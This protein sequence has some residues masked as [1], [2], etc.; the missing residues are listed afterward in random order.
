MLQPVGRVLYY[1]QKPAHKVGRRFIGGLAMVARFR[2][3]RQSPYPIH[4]LI[5][6]IV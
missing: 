2:F 4:A 6:L 3:H 1:A 5:Q